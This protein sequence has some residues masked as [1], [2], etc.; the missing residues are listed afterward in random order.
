M[1]AY[2]RIARLFV[3]ITS[4]SMVASAAHA[5]D[6]FYV[7]APAGDF[8]DSANWN[9]QADGLGAALTSP[10]IDVSTTKIEHSLVIDGDMVAAGAEVDF[11]L[12]SLLI[13]TGS[14]FDITGGKLDFDS[15]S[16]FTMAGST[17][18]VG[19]GSS[20]AANQISL[21]DGSNL[22]LTGATVTAGDDIFLRGTLSIINSS[23]ESTNDDV[24][25]RE[26]ASVTTISG[27]SFTASN[28]G[29][30]GGLNQLVI[31]QTST[32]AITDSF[33]RGGRLGIDGSGTTQITATDS[34]FDFDGDIENAY[35]SSGG[36]IH[37]LTLAGNSTLEGDQLEEDVKIFLKDS[38]QVTLKDDLLDSDGDSW[39][40]DNSFVRIDSPDAALHL[41]NPQNTDTRAKVFNGQTFTTYSADSS[42]FSPNNWNG[43]DAVTLTIVPEPT[44]AALVVVLMGLATMGRRRA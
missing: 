35:T 33:F 16:S 13:D 22:S 40:N 2:T 6:F 43:T 11:G 28:V 32:T 10:I 19:V 9:D 30:G 38:S 14:V 26:T 12:G 36:G 5:M 7:G 44:S 4:V 42:V 18:N 21:D 27:S 37:I 8:F 34:I 39:I 3:A 29:S 24:E 1:K 25:I 20:G 41:L 15:G 31:L 23:L 17:L